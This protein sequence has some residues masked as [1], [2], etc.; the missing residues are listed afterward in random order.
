M[1]TIISF[2]FP[3]GYDVLEGINSG[4][5]ANKLISLDNKDNYKPNECFNIKISLNKIITIYVK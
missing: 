5:F 3:K 2:E 4:A 1:K